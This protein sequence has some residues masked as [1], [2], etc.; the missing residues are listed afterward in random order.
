MQQWTAQQHRRQIEEDY[1]TPTY[2]SNVTIHNSKLHNNTANLF[3]GT[4]ASYNINVTMYNSELYSNS[5]IQN[6]GALYIYY[7][8]ALLN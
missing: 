3:G 1:S 7:A 4:L 2:S 6:S 8:L 5:A